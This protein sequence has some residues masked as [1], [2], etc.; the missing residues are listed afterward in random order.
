MSD[1]PDVWQWQRSLSESSL[2]GS[3][4]CFSSWAQRRRAARSLAISCP[5][6]HTVTLLRAPEHA[7]SSLCGSKCCFSSWVQRRHVACSLAISYDTIREAISTCTRK[8]TWVS[9]IY[10]T[11][12][13]AKKWE[14]EKKLENGYAVSYTTQSQYCR[15]RSMLSLLSVASKTKCLQR[16]AGC[17]AQAQKHSQFH[18]TSGACFAKDVTFPDSQPDKYERIEASV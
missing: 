15:C 5:I 11:E 14:N 2:C 12:P 6:H 4:C 18:P 13:T 16:P 9:L 1:Q 8:P 3:K 7:K 10:R 17:A